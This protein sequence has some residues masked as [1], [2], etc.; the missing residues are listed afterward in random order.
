MGGDNHENSRSFF[1][2]SSS[3]RRWGISNIHNSSTRARRREHESLMRI[4]VCVC[5]CVCVYIYIK[6]ASCVGE[7]I[8]HKLRISAQQKE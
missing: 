6:R 1:Y 8:K 2:Y 5:V 7:Q 3:V 4:Y